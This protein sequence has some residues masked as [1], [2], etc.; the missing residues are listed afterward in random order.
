M[1]LEEKTIPICLFVPRQRCFWRR[2]CLLVTSLKR[3]LKQWKDT[4]TATHHIC[5]KEIYGKH[6][7]SDSNEI[8]HQERFAINSSVFNLVASH[9]GSKSCLCPALP[10]GRQEPFALLHRSAA[11]PYKPV[12]QQVWIS[13]E[14]HLK[15]SL[16]RS[17][18]VTTYL[19]NHSFFIL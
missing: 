19:G 12:R 8:R 11:N 3:A 16:V 1:N 7:M 14:K 18:N 4:A 9:F 17:T 15:Q 6:F 5:N 2:L 10:L 13:Q